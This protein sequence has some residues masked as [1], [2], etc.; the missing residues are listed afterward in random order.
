MRGTDRSTR[1]A[2]FVN[3]YNALIV[4]SNAQMGPPMTLF[5]RYKV[6]PSGVRLGF[7]DNGGTPLQFFN[8]TTYLIGSRRF[9]LLWRHNDS[10]LY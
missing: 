9:A 3:V 10:G 6:R 8:T 5:D 4:H 7:S 2:F 1:L